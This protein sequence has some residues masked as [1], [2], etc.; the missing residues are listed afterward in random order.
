M[1]TG[2]H[3]GA[4]ERYAIAGRLLGRYVDSFATDADRKAQRET[5]ER[6]S[7]LA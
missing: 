6:A 4:I 5:S 2:V 1:L 3:A 7:E